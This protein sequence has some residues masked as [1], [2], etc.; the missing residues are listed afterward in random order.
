MLGAGRAFESSFLGIASE[1]GEHLHAERDWLVLASVFGGCAALAIGVKA[2]ARTWKDDRAVL[3]HA[4]A[5][6]VDAGREALRLLSLH[7]ALIVTMIAG[8]VTYVVALGMVMVRAGQAGLFGAAVGLTMLATPLL[9]ALLEAVELPAAERAVARAE[10]VGVE[11]S[12]EATQA[13]RAA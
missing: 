11:A 6:S 9:V 5:R 10:G 3:G 1:I 8:M 4:G 12:A 7:E 13:R 2:L